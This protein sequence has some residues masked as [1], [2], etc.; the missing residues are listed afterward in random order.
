MKNFTYVHNWMWKKKSSQ[1]CLRVFCLSVCFFPL[2]HCSKHEASRGVHRRRDDAR[3]KL[4][5]P[6][7]IQKHSTQV[8]SQSVRTSLCD[9]LSQMLSWI[10]ENFPRR[11]FF[12]R[13]LQN[14]MKMFFSDEFFPTK[15]KFIR[16]FLS[17]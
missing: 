3:V 9:T 15:N 17:T 4:I 2:S 8:P 16:K 5:P 14:F 1:I 7:R 12:W 11:V 6:C 13:E 10:L